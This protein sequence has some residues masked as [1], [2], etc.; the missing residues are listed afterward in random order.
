MTV[1]FPKVHNNNPLISYKAVNTLKVN[2]KYS[3]SDAVLWKTNA[4]KQE[5]L[6]T[7]HD[8]DSIVK[9]SIPTSAP[10]LGKGVE[11]VA[12]YLIYKGRDNG[13]DILEFEDGPGPRQ[14][15]CIVYDNQ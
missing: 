5:Q 14:G 2:Y 6:L 11:I 10:G 4:G 9:I 7:L 3:L 13:M 15:L 8:G 12:K 1:K